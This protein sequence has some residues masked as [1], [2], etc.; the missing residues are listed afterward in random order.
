[1]LWDV[2][3]AAAFVV[4]AVAALVY[5]AVRFVFTCLKGSQPLRCL[6]LSPLSS[7]WRNRS[8]PMRRAIKAHSFKSKIL[9]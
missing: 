8:G 9:S 3:V 4:V 6:I 7:L 1:M 5:C 2:I